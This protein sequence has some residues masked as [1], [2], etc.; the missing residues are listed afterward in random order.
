MAYKLR[1]RKL[2]ETEVNGKKFTFT[3]YSQDTNYGF[4]HICTLGY[5]DTTEC[6]YIKR[7]IISKACYYN[8]TWERFAYET[9]LRNAIEKLPETKEIRD[10]LHAILIEHKAQDEHEKCEKF[11]ND[12]QDTWNSMSDKNKE[13]VRNGLGDNLITSSEQADSLLG[14]MKLMNAIDKIGE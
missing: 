6:R 12:F 8:R 4:R 13:H 7:D 10:K 14:I 11:L 3:C 9:V 2:F 5:N 1:N